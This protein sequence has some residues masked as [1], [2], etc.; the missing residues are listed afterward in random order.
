MSATPYLP[1]LLPLTVSDDAWGSFGM[2]EFNAVSSLAELNGM[3]QAS[4]K[5][6]L[7]WLTW[8]LQEARSSNVIEGTVTTFEEILGENAGVVVPAERQD[9]VREVINYKEAT[10]AGLQ[11]INN[12]RD[13]TLS[14]VKSL[15][16]LL[17]EGARGEKK[18][19]GQ[20]RTIQ[21]HIGRPGS[22]P[23]TATYIPP[24]SV[25]VPALLENWEK[26][27]HRTDLNPLIQAAVMHAQFEMI[28]PFCDGNG[29]MGRLL[30]T[31]WIILAV[32]VIVVLEPKATLTQAVFEIVSALGTVGLTLD[33][34]PHLCVA[35]KMVVALTM[36]V[37]LVG[38]ITLLACFIRHQ[39]VKLYTYPDETVIV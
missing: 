6:D 11:A 1:P 14:L 36:F 2:L 21:V 20:Y 15:H 32:F 3:M 19:P 37:G 23:E 18:N 16:A 22:T 10:E 39:E 17:L 33:L 8:L 13:I 34:T 12:G 29:R 35:S 31:L 25:H 24:D 4:A 27:L 5:A 7:F 9:D 26:F 30:T 28:H 38:L